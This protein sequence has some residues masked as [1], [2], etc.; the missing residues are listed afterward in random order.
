MVV[1]KDAS[2]LGCQG[3]RAHGVN[4]HAGT[5]P[6]ATRRRTSISFAVA[7][8]VDVRSREGRYYVTITEKRAIY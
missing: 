1:V 2:R 7:L 4:Q 8:L 5:K 6:A 3:Q